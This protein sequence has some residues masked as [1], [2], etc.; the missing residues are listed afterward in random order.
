MLGSGRG[1][2]EDGDRRVWVSN[3]AQDGTDG[4][5]KLCDGNI[6][7]SIYGELMLDDTNSNS[8][9]P[10]LLSKERLTEESV[11][12]LPLPKIYQY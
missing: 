4:G 9:R 12:G 8:D 1:I 5:T 6:T 3:T 10:V 2:G 11:T 7:T